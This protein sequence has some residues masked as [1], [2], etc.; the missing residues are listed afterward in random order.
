MKKTA[1]PGMK[2]PMLTTVGISNDVATSGTGL[3]IDYQTGIENFRNPYRSH[4]FQWGMAEVVTA[5]LNTGLTLKIFKEY[6]YSNSCKLFER[7]RET[8]DRRNFP[9]EDVPNLPLMYGIV[10]QK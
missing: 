6:S 8:S 5:L 2:R 4:E 7:M 3:A 1:C 9:P 10:A